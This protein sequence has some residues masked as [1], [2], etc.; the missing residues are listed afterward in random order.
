MN[1][2][3]RFD[4]PKVE[5]ELEDHADTSESLH[6]P[7]KKYEMPS[8]KKNDIVNTFLRDG[9]GPLAGCSGIKDVEWCGFKEFMGSK[10]VKLCAT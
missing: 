1:A 8:R 2:D 6:D 5:E 10:N 7:K 3:G 9:P 4:E